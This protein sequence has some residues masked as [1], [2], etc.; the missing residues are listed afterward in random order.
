M[1]EVLG[2]VDDRQVDAKL[3]RALLGVERDRAWSKTTPGV[4]SPRF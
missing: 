2:R 3:A 4:M 1:R